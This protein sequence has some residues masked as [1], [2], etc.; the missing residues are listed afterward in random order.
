MIKFG[1]IGYP[2]RHSLSPCFWNLYFKKKSINAIY[3]KIEIPLCKSPDLKGYRG[4][5]VTTPWKENILKYVDFIHETALQTKNAN[6]IFIDMGIQAF[7]T[8]YY[9]FEK[10]IDELKLDFENV[11]ILGTGGA[12]KT[13]GF[14]F[15]KKNLTKV[16]FLSRSKTGKIFGYSI[17]KYR[18]KDIE[19]LLYNACLLI[20]AT[21]TGWQGELPPI[22]FNHIRK[23]FL[24][25]L[26]YG[27]ETPF[28]KE[29]KKYGLRGVD[30]KKM[31]LYQAIYAGRIWFSDFD[32]E[33]FKE[34]F[35]KIME[36]KNA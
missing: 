7:N 12:A 5:N 28:L 9:G 10:F 14:Y 21:P 20:N 31:L 4:L 27:K 33:C 36:D 22:N 34:C 11:V 30:G 18:D 29:G 8:D 3:K 35:N 19:G 16:Y 17:K 25:D 13:C 2:L 24:I 1:I 6:T 23:A 32:E 15:K 26:Q